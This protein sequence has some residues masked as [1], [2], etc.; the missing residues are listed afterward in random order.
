MTT[1]ASYTIVY[2]LHP[3]IALFSA[4]TVAQSTRQWQAKHCYP[5]NP[6]KS[7]TIHQLSKLFT[8]QYFDS[9]EQLTFSNVAF[10]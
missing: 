10:M 2:T 5:A 6:G 9:L 1:H 4:F 7:R 3:V 8:F